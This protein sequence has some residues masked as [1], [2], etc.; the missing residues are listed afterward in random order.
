MGDSKR[1]TCKQCRAAVPPHRRSLCDRCA[2]SNKKSHEKF[3]NDRK[4]ERRRTDPDYREKCLEYQ[5][6]WWRARRE[7]DTHQIRE[8]R[9][10]EICGG[11]IP[12]KL[13]LSA[14]H[15][16]KYHPVGELK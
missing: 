7:I 3:N 16:K 10:C 5:R 12:Y 13:D 11:P 8:T 9:R 4:L 14:K 15:C 1:T 2:E 6:E